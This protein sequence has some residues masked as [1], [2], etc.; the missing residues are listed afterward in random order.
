MGENSN[1]F[2][3]VLAALAIF[4]LAK[5]F[6]YKKNSKNDEILSE[7]K[8]LDAKNSKKYAYYFTLL[9]RNLELN[10]REKRLFEEIVEDMKIYKYRQNPK[11]LDSKT[12]A[13]IEVF[14]GAFE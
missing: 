6:S 5:K 11:N 10:E 13:K 2:F 4:V 12:V 1:V 7:L 14:F 8:A 9:G 3:F